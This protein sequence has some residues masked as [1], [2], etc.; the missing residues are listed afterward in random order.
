M[1]D[2]KEYNATYALNSYV[3]KVLEAN[4][5]WVKVKNRVPIVPLN[6]E[7][8]MMETGK[9]FIVYGS[10]KPSAGHLYDH[11]RV[12][13]SY[14][15][16]AGTATALNKIAELLFDVLKRQD[17]S[18][19][20]INDW[21]KTEAGSRAGGHRGVYFT[22]VRAYAVETVDNDEKEGGWVTTT[23]IVEMTYTTEPQEIKTTGFTA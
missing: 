19:A 23:L 20:D 16:V 21:L 8:E 3:W 17:D 7:P 9:D 13:T 6:Q 5:G 10:S 4:L 15:I 22:S 14:N 18:A 2:Y 12:V 1:T 11:K